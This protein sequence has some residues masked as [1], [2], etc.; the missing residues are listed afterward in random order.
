MV[1]TIDVVSARSLASYTLLAAT[2]ANRDPSRP[3]TPPP[4]DNEPE[5]KFDGKLV[6]NVVDDVTGKPVEGALVAPDM[7]VEDEGVVASPLHLCRRRRN[8]SL[9]HKT[10]N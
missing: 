3:I 1:E 10:Y 6:I 4:A 5:R 9:S 7:T 2:V 8:H